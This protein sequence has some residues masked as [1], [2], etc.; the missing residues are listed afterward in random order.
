MS[1]AVVGAVGQNHLK[2]CIYLLIHLFSCSAKAFFISRS[3]LSAVSGN[4]AYVSV[5]A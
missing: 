3:V 2:I 4:C 1:D 5:C